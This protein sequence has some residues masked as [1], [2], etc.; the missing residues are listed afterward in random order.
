MTLVVQPPNSTLIG[1]QPDSLRA[2]WGLPC[3]EPLGPA[4]RMVAGSVLWILAMVDG[5]QQAKAP[6]GRHAP[7]S[8]RHSPEPVNQA[9][10]CVDPRILMQSNAHATHAHV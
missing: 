2:C 3:Q 10:V 5:S 7:C 6:G 8:Q 9:A 1:F 4:N